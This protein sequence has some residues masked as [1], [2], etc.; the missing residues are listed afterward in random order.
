MQSPSSG[1]F[2]T[3]V[4]QPGFNQGSQG[5]VPIQTWEENKFTENTGKNGSS[6]SDSNQ[7]QF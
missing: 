6:V 4:W 5:P 7:L 3:Y 2:T 1:N